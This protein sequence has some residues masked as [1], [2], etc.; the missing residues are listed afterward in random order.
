ML[1]ATDAI[2][3]DGVVRYVQSRQNDDGSFGGDEWSKWWC[4]IDERRTSNI[5]NRITVV[6]VVIDCVSCFIPDEVDTRFSFCALASLY[7][8][9]SV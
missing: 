8:L 9:V 4:V 5:V 3:C 1:N 7:L 6:L 2:D